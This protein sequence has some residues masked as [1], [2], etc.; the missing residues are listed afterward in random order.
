M[1]N[2]NCSCPYCE[3]QR[4]ALANGSN[5]LGEFLAS[6]ASARI[7]DLNIAGA[8]TPNME[9]AAPMGAYDEYADLEFGD[10]GWSEVIILQAFRPE[11]VEDNDIVRFKR[12]HEGD[13][14]WC[15]ADKAWKKHLSFQVKRRQDDVPEQPAHKVI[16]IMEG[17][18]EDRMDVIYLG[19]FPDVMEASQKAR[20]L[21]PNQYE[22]SILVTA[23]IAAQMAE[24]L[25]EMVAKIAD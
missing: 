5:N 24:D 2:P 23:N 16:M 12:S 6:I 18:D 13:P 7:S 15:Y 11:W 8:A 21:F 19:D 25:L 22:G 17:R 4:R 9:N 20:E 1:Y 14:A 3:G 10:D